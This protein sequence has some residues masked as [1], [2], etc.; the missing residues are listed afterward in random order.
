MSKISIEEALKIKLPLPWKVT[1]PTGTSFLVARRRPEDLTKELFE[2]LDAYGVIRNTIRELFYISSSNF[3]SVMKRLGIPIGKRGGARRGAGKPAGSVN[4]KK[5]DASSESALKTTPP[6]ELP[7]IPVDPPF[8]M[9]D[10][11]ATV[12][13]PEPG[14]AAAQFAEMAA[15]PLDPTEDIDGLNYQ[16]RHNLGI[17]DADSEKFTDLANM[18][19]P[20]RPVSLRD[21]AAKLVIAI[22]A[23][24]AADR[25]IAYYTAEIR[26][27]A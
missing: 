19:G 26:R 9:H 6:A 2:Q 3:S 7:K 20:E 17:E 25:D 24:E 15:K 16:D 27:L 23:R 5:P 4:K 13:A 14:S 10:V 22:D 8:R 11:A 18:S 1:D 12:L 21:C